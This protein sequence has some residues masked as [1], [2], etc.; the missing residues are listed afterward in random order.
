MYV[1]RLVDAIDDLKGTLQIGSKLKAFASFAQ[2][3]MLSRLAHDLGKQAGG[4]KKQQQ[5]PKGQNA[6]AGTAPSQRAKIL[7]TRAASQVE[8]HP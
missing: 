7:S 2:F 5:H 6:S 8:A 3:E 1:E 4:W